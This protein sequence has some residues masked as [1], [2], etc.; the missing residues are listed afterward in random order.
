MRKI[1]MNRTVLWWIFLCLC[2]FVNNVH[3]EQSEVKKRKWRLSD[4]KMQLSR[5]L[6]DSLYQSI[7]ADET[8]N[9]IVEFVRWNYKPMA[10]QTA[11]SS[12]ESFAV[13]VEKE[14]VVLIYTGTSLLFKENDEPYEAIRKISE[15]LLVESLVPSDESR[16][17]DKVK[18]SNQAIML[19][20]HV[21]GDDLGGYVD[22]IDILLKGRNAVVVLKRAMARHPRTPITYEGLGL[23]ISWRD[24]N[25]FNPKQWK[26]VPKAKGG[27]SPIFNE[28]DQIEA[29]PISL[30]NGC[31]WPMVDG[32]LI[33]S[34]DVCSARS[35]LPKR[36]P[37]END[38]N[39]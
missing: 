5:V 12:K 37:Q 28:E 33:D 23:A 2:I 35:I 19:C 4:C 9:R 18:R 11:L 17:S 29:I 27:E 22:N 7:I 13:R 14:F 31:V 32:K 21:L 20:Y 15:T 39:R 10:V 30:L 36:N 34:E 8:D 26:D 6:S 1:I 38:G 24:I 25:E 3:A 16:Y